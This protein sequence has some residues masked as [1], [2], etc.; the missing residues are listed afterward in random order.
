MSGLFARIISWFA[1]EIIVKTLSRS[2]RFQRFAL[3]TDDFL[4]R[5]KKA[6][7]EHA[8]KM[9]ANIDA[10]LQEAKNISRQ[11]STPAKKPPP[12]ARR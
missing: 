2:N 10:I 9:P 12:T 5:N 11:Q 8:K 4:V 1:E 7:E 3:H 6:L